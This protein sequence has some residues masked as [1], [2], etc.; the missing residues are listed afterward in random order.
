MY[1]MK[2]G[3]NG[4]EVATAESGEDALKKIEG[5]Y[6]PD[7]LL[8]DV[9]MPNIDGLELLAEIR[10]ENLVP[11]ATVIM[12]TNQSDNSDIERAKALKVNG[13]IVKATTIPSDVITEVTRIHQ[14]SSK[15]S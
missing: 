5:G 2:F 7:I 13:Y 9:I 14:T 3:K 1:S 8:L 4:F 6:A 10:K 12:L 15:P 11:K